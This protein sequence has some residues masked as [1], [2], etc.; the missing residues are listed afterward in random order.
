MSD[1][2]RNVLI[3]D[4]NQYLREILATMLR[5]SGSEISQ[6]A[7]GSEAPKKA[8]SVKPNLILLD[9]DLPDL[10]GAEVARAIRKQTASAH[11]YLSSVAV[12]FLGGNGG[13][14][15]YMRG[16]SIT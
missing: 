8:V 12:R 11:I 6:A 9:I 7:N 3:V 4:D 15:R 10:A 16:W 2:S 13:K 1:M 14:R 5:F